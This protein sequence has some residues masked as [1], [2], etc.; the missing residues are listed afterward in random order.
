MVSVSN[1]SE[2][3]N[4]ATYRDNQYCADL[5]AKYGEGETGWLKYMESIMMTWPTRNGDAWNM[6]GTGKS[7]TM[8]MA[9]FTYKNKSGTTVDTF[10]AAA[11]SAKTPTRN[12]L[13]A[14]AGLAYGDW[15]MPDIVEMKKIFGRW[16]TSGTSPVQ[17]ALAKISPS[18]TDSRSLA[19]AR[20]APAR[21]YNGSAWI[22]NFSG[23][24]GSNAFFIN[25]RAVA[26]ALLK[27]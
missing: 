17:K 16:N 13:P 21:L 12:S 15:Y 3:M 2:I 20:W 18:A 4:L 22:L 9:A 1:G 23:Y 8:R 6:Y 25:G 5:R 19:V 14:S 24:F 7:L 26:V 11:W 27:L 10:K